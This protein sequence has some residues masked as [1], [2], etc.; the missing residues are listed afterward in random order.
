M[1]IEH[2]VKGEDGSSKVRN[3]DEREERSKE[4]R[5]MRRGGRRGNEWS[6]QKL[7][8]NSDQRMHN[9]PKYSK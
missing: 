1:A 4:T 6:R 3:G 8:E 9:T 2:R 5:D 7:N